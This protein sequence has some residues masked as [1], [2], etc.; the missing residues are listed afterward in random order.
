MT[1]SDLLTLA[2]LPLDD[3]SDLDLG[4]R[5]T[6]GTAELRAAVAASYHTIAPDSVLTSAGAQ[7][8]LCWVLAKLL[9]DGG[10]AVVGVPN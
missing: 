7:E 9:S 3:F 5:P 8:A 1:I 10:H 2:G 6:F 4:Y